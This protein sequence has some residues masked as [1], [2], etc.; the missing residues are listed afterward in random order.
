MGSCVGC[1]TKIPMFTALCW[2]CKE[3]NRLSGKSKDPKR[4]IKEPE[5]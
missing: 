3:E 2:R 4:P 5:E 1:G